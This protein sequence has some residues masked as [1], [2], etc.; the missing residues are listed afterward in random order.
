[1]VSW[2]YFPLSETSKRHCSKFVHVHA[3]WDC[4]LDLLHY[5]LKR[6]TLNINS[7]KY[8]T[9]F[10]GYV[11]RRNR[12]EAIKLKQNSLGRLWLKY[13]FGI[14]R[15][16]VSL[17]KWTLEHN[18]TMSFIICFLPFTLSKHVG[19]AC[20]RNYTNK[21]TWLSWSTL[22]RCKDETWET[23]KS[24]LMNVEF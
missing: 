5:T 9:C 20:K 16:D 12:K 14:L 19:A 2:T 10:A 21:V 18:N 6:N 8:T 13:P 15:F 3:W 24:I 22:M 11:K 23:W 1:M 7:R 17:V 4:M